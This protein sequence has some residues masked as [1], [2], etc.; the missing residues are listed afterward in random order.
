M[1]TRFI[2]STAALAVLFAAAPVSADWN[3]GDP[4]KMH[5]PQLP[6]PTGWDL[7]MFTS[8]NQL[9]DD[10]QCSQTGPVND[11]HFWTSWQGDNA[12]STE[13]IPGRIDSIKVEIYS[14]VPAV[15]G[16]PPFSQPGQLLWERNFLASEFTVRPA[17]TGEQ[18]FYRPLGGPTDFAKPD[19]FL[20]QQV[21]IAD[22]LDP[23][24][25][26]EGTI[27]WLALYA[28]WFT[29]I[30]SP[31]GWKTSQD[32]FNDAAVFLNANIPPVPQWEPLFDPITGEV[33][34]LAFVI[35]SDPATLALMT[36]GGLAL[37]RRR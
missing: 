23:F 10:W 16:G 4:Y 18:G 2:T 30:Q 5:Y 26:Q 3:V 36:L 9:A 28:D 22:I 17:G 32:H 37:L 35:T 31:V 6:D 27:Y 14:D 15:P 12:P 34:D 19:H 20:Y 8:Q 29:G 24:T 33:L 1:L 25:Q 7:E 21:N 11:I 13:P